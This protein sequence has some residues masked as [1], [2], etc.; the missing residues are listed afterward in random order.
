VT[1]NFK[2]GLT[3][4]D[5]PK[6]LTV[7][8]PKTVRPTQTPVIASAGIALSPYQASGDY[9]STTPRQ[10]VLWIEFAEPLADATDAYFGRVLGYGPDPLL[11][12]GPSISPD[13]LAA[14]VTEPPISLDPEPVRVI[15]PGQTADT[16]GLD[17]MT[18]L[19]PALPQL[20]PGGKPQPIRHFLLPMPP[21]IT[22]DSPELFGF[23]TYE[24][25]VGHAGTG[26]SNWSTA[27]ARFGRPLRVAGMQHR[28]RC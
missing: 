1:P 22:P 4:S 6:K 8:L 18:Q 19:V 23:W 10:R 3:T 27:Q 16:A 25:R 28:R 20:G 21:G 15:A 12:F 9:S 24:L 17:A 14:D 13:A 7:D 11:A 5:P 2:A 26:L